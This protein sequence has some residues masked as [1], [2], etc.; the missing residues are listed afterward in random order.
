MFL[1]FGLQ[2]TTFAHNQGVRRFWRE[3]TQEVMM[4]SRIVRI[5]ILT[6]SIWIAGS[7][8]AQSVYQV[9]PTFDSVVAPS[10]HAFPGFGAGFRQQIVVAATRLAGLPRTNS[11][12]K[13][14]WIRRNLAHK[15]AI[16]GGL[17]DLEIRI[18]PARRA[19]DKVSPTF[20]TNIPSTQKLVFKGRVTIPNAPSLSGNVSP[21]STTNSVRI[22][23]GSPYVYQGGNLC[24]DVIGR[25]V[26]GSEP[27][28]WRIDCER[29]NYS[30]SS[31]RLGKSCSTFADQNGETLYNHDLWLQIGSTMR[32][33]AMGRPGSLPLL[34]LGARAVPGGY[35]LTGMGATG[36]RQHISY[37][38]VAALTYSKP[39]FAGAAAVL[40]FETQIPA[41]STLLGASVFTQ[42]ADD[43]TALPR[44]E[45]SNP[46]G[47]T[48]SNGLELK[49]SS[50]KPSL[51][52][53]LVT[54]ED[55]AI[56][57]SPKMGRVDVSTG[58][59]MRLLY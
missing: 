56:V 49:I 2:S 33:K 57:P 42:F 15:F 50:V 41:N 21:W 18:S 30:G 28:T 4:P 27:D 8:T 54:S 43:E 32:L 51:G 48:T 46:A 19:P 37:F 55:L 39:P 31:K 26:K 5:V 53:S 23:F 13:G 7:A 1:H 40:K 11:S 20:S 24:I 17:A 6:L 22:A 47:L 16:R 45:W 25:P 58:P 34:L 12:L 29:G 10:T 9:S 59:V 3:D 52:I 36:C 14:M 38:L 44:T 35:D